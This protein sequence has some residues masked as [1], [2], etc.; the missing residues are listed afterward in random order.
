[1]LFQGSIP[2]LVTPMRGGEID[3]AAYRRFIS[4]QIEQGSH[5]VVAVGTTG[6]SPTVSMEEHKRLVEI[7]V[8]EAKGRVFVLAGTGSNS[9]HEAIELTVHAHRAGADGALVVVPYY[10]KPTQEGLY[11]HFS[12]VSQSAPIPIVLY[13]V[14]SRTVTS[15]APE[16]IA[17]LVRDHG[18]IVGIKDATADLVR[19][20]EQRRLCGSSFIQLSG[21]D[22]TALAFNIS[23]GVGCISVTANVAPALCAQFQ[24]AC[25][26]KD[27]EEALAIQMRLLPLHR[28]LFV[29]SNPAPAKYALSLLG[30]MSDEVRLPLLPLS[31]DGQKKVRDV[32][33][34]VGLLPR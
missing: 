16:T 32:M 12:A 29:E 2:A 17:R 5:G 7:A 4:W 11:A 19:P 8:D 18:N 22:G 9:T 26:R 21:E 31:E 3:E 14:P 24:M 30:L 15:L 13:D 20:I 28:V 25:A 6:E 23:G 27:Y 10:N 34:E 1:M 33:G